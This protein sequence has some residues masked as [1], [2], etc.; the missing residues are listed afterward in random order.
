VLAEGQHA[1][2]IASQ[3]TAQAQDLL[4][5][6]VAAVEKTQRYRAVLEKP[7]VQ[8]LLVEKDGGRGNATSS[9]GR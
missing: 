9:A 5:A 6:Q 1:G 2:S 3:A 8:R 7:R 4:V